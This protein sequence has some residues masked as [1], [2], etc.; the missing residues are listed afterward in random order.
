MRRP[1][2]ARAPANA[3]SGWL[4][5]APALILLLFAASGPLLIMLVYSFLTPGQYGNVE[6][7]FSLDAWVGMLY[8]R[9]IFDGE[10]KLADAHLSIFWRSVKL[11]IYTTLFAFVFGF[12]TAWYIAT[13]GAAGTHR[14]AVPDHHPVLDQPAD[15]HLRDQPDHP[16]RGRAEHLPAVDSA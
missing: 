16:Q 4:L 2:T 10:L 9:D 13:R 12:P 14:A 1:R 7:D 5:S 15:P 6:W 3:R 8:S 11:S